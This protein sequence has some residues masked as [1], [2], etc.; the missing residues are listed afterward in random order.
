MTA[1]GEQ[2]IEV[3]AMFEDAIVSVRHLRNPT[4][5]GVRRSTRI[6][7]GAGAASLLGALGAFVVTYVQV[8]ALRHAWDAAVVAGAQGAFE[9]PRDGRW[10]DG[11]A[12]LALVFGAYALARGLVQ[13]FAEQ[14]AP[15]F[16]IGPA[17]GSD[18][19]APGA[20][21]PVDAFPLVHA[22][23]AGY[24]LVYTDAMA[25]ELTVDGG[26]PVALAAL[27]KAR[28]SHPSSLPGSHAVPLV[29]GVRVQVELGALRFFVSSVAAPAELP[30][31]L[32]IDWAQEAYIGAAALAAGIF[33][34]LIYQIPPDAQSL[35]LDVMR[36]ERFAHFVITPPAEPILVDPRGSGVSH[37][38]GSGR[39][40]S[41]ESGALGSP[42]A[43]RRS[44]QFRLKRS[45]VLTPEVAQ[46]AAFDAV[47]NIGVLGQMRALEGTHVGA[48]FTPEHALGSD[49]TTVLAGLIGTEVQD[50][51]GTGLG[52]NGPGH[53]GG[54]TG[55]K[56]IG[57]GRLP[58]V[59]HYGPGHD[60]YPPGLGAPPP[61]VHK[62]GAVH[63]PEVPRFSVGD[64]LDKSLV[65]RVIH[66]HLNEVRFCYE[67]ELVKNGDLGGRV[68]TQFTIAGTGR[69]LGA[70]VVGSTMNSPPVEHCIADSVRRW[71]FPQPAGGGVVVVSYPFLLQR[72]AA[73]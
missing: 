41:G 37:G 13:L 50:A 31:A 57:I 3:A 67:K 9:L 16:V 43:K 52:I 71:E 70:S 12:A 51:Y 48:I 44:G 6:L 49:E 22:T 66:Q 19:A 28:L 56:S 25:G 60:G 15:G 32:R 40:H 34:A 54:G 17:A 2:A 14:R 27:H 61:M 59:G 72:A 68:M 69:V 11:A 30:R 63:A 20:Q 62:V 65:R 24:E 58:T 42:A 1:S 45:P 18:V 36:S 47:Q 39:A 8:G 4:G 33:L 10:L 64:G 29:E 53:G 5:G 55:D 35:S 38:G 26:P 73:Q 23:G 46:K 7:I 21:L